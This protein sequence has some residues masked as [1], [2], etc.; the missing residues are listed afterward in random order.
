MG[1]SHLLK[2]K[3]GAYK[4]DKSLINKQTIFLLFRKGNPLF[5]VTLPIVEQKRRHD[6]MTV[7]DGRGHARTFDNPL[8]GNNTKMRKVKSKVQLTA[9]QI[10]IQHAFED[11]RHFFIDASAVARVG[12]IKNGVWLELHDGRKFILETDKD[13]RNN[14]WKAL[15]FNPQYPLDVLYDLFVVPGEWNKAF[16]QE[17]TCPH[18]NS[19]FYGQLPKCPN[20]NNLVT[21]GD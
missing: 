16:V 8:F 11:G 7:F 2:A 14:M 12:K 20:C 6:S 10:I 18:C 9:Q 5:I 13:I 3:T 4:I 1:I 17:Y 15:G 19:S 21:F